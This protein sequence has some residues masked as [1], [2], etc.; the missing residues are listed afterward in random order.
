MA[1]TYILRCSDGSFYV[2]SARDLDQ[3]MEQHAQGATDSFTAKRLPVGLV[4]YEQFDRIDDAFVA[5]RKIKGWRREKKQALIEGRFRD[6]PAL[7][8]NRQS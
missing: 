5:E 2:G 4:W 8:A 7:S 1:Y 6:L 3:R